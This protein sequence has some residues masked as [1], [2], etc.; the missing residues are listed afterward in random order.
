M[1]ECDSNVI[2]YFSVVAN[3]KEVN[4]LHFLLVL[5]SFYLERIAKMQHSDFN[6][7]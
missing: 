3:R 2:D 5:S 6:I 1:I 7:K 4:I